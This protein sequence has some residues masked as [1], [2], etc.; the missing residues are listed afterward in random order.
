MGLHDWYGYEFY[1]GRMRGDCS[2]IVGLWATTI[3]VCD[4]RSKAE[5]P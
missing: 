3:L 5:I 4:K 1:D 2:S